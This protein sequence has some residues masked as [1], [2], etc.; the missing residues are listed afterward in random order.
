MSAGTSF[1]AVYFLPAVT[2]LTRRLLVYFDSGAYNGPQADAL[3]RL[4]AKRRQA[5]RHAV[6]HIQQLRPG[7]PLPLVTRHHSQLIREALSVEFQLLA[8][9][10]VEQRDLRAS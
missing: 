9:G 3:R 1:P 10:A 5:V 4:D 6:R 7:E 8:D 2:P